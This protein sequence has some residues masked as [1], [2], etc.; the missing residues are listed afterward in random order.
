MRRLVLLVLV[1]AATSLAVTAVPSLAAK[2]DRV[3]RSSRS[4][5]ATGSS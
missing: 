1:L 4:P 5:A 2:Q 3:P